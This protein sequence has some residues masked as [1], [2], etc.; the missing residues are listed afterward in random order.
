MGRHASASSNFTPTPLGTH[1]ARCIRVIDIGT[2]HGEYK[3]EPSVKNQ[4]VVVFE[5]PQ[6]L[7]EAKDGMKPYVISKY[8][9]NSLAEKATLRAHLVS[10][11]GRDFTDEELDAFDLETIVGKPCLVTV[12]EGTK[13]DKRNISTVTGL[14]KG[15]E[16]PPQV[17]PSFTFWLDE[18]DQK[19]FDALSEGMKRKVMDSDEY[20][21]MVADS[22]P[23][24]AAASAQN[25][26]KKDDDLPF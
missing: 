20:K 1:V 4:V 6:E 5:L 17:N 22:L 24:S 12:V 21:A 19:K 7:Y 14:P 25:E 10:W 16:C 18:F 8:Y 2:Q 13:K 23:G 26:Q 11:R 9:T 3:G 15:M